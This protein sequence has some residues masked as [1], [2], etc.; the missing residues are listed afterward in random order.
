MQRLVGA[1]RQHQQHGGAGDDQG[2]APT[3]RRDGPPR[4]QP[5]IAEQE[6]IDQARERQRGAERADHGRT[7][8]QVEGKRGGKAGGAGERA[9]DP[10]D[11]K[12]AGERIRVDARRSRPE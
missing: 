12:L 3:Q 8:R 9:G 4:S 1:R 7:G 5:R 2:R 11:R 6:R 10:A